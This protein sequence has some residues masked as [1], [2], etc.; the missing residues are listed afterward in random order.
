MAAAAA[1]S[2]KLPESPIYRAVFFLLV[3]LCVALW[4][5]FREGKYAPVATADNNTDKQKKSKKPSGAADEESGA[6]TAP[7]DFDDD[8]TDA[9]TEVHAAVAY[10]KD[11]NSPD[12]VKFK[13]NYLAVYSLVMLS[14][15]LQGSYIYGITF[16]VLP[17]SKPHT[18]KCLSSSAL[19]RNYNFS[20]DQI[21]VLFVVGFLSSAIFGTFVGS[22]ADKVG[23]MR[24]CLAFC[25]IYGISCFTKYFPNYVILLFGRLTGGIATSLLF[26]VFE[27]WMVSEHFSR[28]FPAS[29][30]SDIF[31]WSTFLN[32]S[33]AIGSGVIADWVAGI[34]GPVG[35]FGVAILVLGVCA[36]MIGGSWKENY[37]EQKSDDKPL[38]PGEKSTWQVILQ[39]VD[40]IRND[41]QV[42]S[43]GTMQS[44]FEG[45]MYT[46]VFLWSPVVEKISE[47]DPANKRGVPYGTIFAAFMVSIMLGSIIF[48]ALLTRLA[49]NHEQIIRLAFAIGAWSLFVPVI[50]NDEL[51][52]FLAFN[53]FEFSCGL[54]FPS[55]GT[56]R[57]KFIPEETRA[58]VMN[59]FRIPL[60]LIV[61]IFL[62][63]TKALSSS[64][65]FSLCSTL[66]TLS[67]F[68]ATKLNTSGG[69]QQQQGAAIEMH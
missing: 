55:I 37:G 33:V 45:A 63:N 42:L 52:I 54:Y 14:D 20:L 46:F 3:L 1:Q 23:R 7:D 59:V 28:G 68:F 34:W 29:L 13:W 50:T 51:L 12:Y 62:F 15:W 64:V 4:F 26:S 2:S 57:S 8:D 5:Y 38:N 66:I 43:I 11:V 17:L 18:A 6:T 44:F 65:L 10:D 25:L 22:I 9:G 27:A 48:R 58:T 67:Y 24:M 19:Y 41:F 40:F 16:C 21:A 47:A 30:L 36:I 39:A 69:A 53:A 35:P 60:N 49:W 61:V 31:S 32:S 56:L